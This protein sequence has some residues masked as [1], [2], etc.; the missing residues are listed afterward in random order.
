MKLVYAI[1]NSD[2]IKP[3]GRDISTGTMVN[4]KK[5]SMNGAIMR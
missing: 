2:D 1:V 4:T 5:N 3:I